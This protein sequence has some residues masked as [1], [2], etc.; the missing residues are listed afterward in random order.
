MNLPQAKREEEE[1]NLCTAQWTPEQEKGL[2]QLR[3]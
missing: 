1:A 3:V 2:Q